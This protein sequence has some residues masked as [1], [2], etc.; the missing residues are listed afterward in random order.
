[1]SFR[2]TAVA[3]AALVTVVT[4]MASVPTVSAQPYPSPGLRDLGDHEFPAYVQRVR[5]RS[6]RFALYRGSAEWGAG[7]GTPLTYCGTMR[8][9]YFRQSKWRL[10]R[11]IRI[12]RK[13]SYFPHGIGA[14]SMDLRVSRR[15]IRRSKYPL[16]VKFVPKVT[17]SGTNLTM[18]SPWSEEIPETIR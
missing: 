5:S 3:I 18:V 1:M 12:R 4:V 9:Q 7:F 15:T 14:F 13:C 16:Q 17:Q 8:V 2:Y 6:Q 10:Y 11:A